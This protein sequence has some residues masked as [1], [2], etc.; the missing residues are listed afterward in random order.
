MIIIGGTWTIEL[1]PSRQQQARKGYKR[2]VG[3]ITQGNQTHNQ[4]KEQRA[5]Y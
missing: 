5:V 4:W 2:Q 1:K 3:T